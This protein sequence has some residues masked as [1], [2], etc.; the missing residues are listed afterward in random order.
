MLNVSIKCS[1]PSL[2]NN[3]LTIV[4]SFAVLEQSRVIAGQA[5]RA[6]CIVICINP[7]P[8]K[9][10][11]EQ[12]NPCQNRFV[13][14]QNA[15]RDTSILAV[16]LMNHFCLSFSITVSDILAPHECSEANLCQAS[17]LIQ[18][19]SAKKVDEQR[20]S[21]P[22]KN[23]GKIVG[24]SIFRNNPFRPLLRNFQKKPFLLS[25]WQNVHYRGVSHHVCLTLCASG[26]RKWLRKKS[27]VINHRVYT[28]TLYTGMRYWK[29]C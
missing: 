19:L 8:L 5:G 12:K 22:A 25:K 20:K 4:I 3:P 16:N 27:K 28:R 14:L 21:E 17:A 13:I 18:C 11:T 6:R 24:E 9:W 7:A 1:T 15:Q 2:D 23:G 10:L 29:K 26:W